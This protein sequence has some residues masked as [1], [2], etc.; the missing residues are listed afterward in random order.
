MEDIIFMIRTL[1]LFILVIVLMMVIVKHV[2][3]TSKCK[4]YLREVLV[5]FPHLLSGP[6]YPVY[7]S[8]PSNYF[9]NYTIDMMFSGVG[10]LEITRAG[11]TVYGK[12]MNGK[13]FLRR[14]S[15]RNSRVK[16]VGR[17]WKHGG[18][19]NWF[20]IEEERRELY[21]SGF[22]GYTIIG[23]KRYTKDLFGMA[24]EVL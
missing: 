19:V 18:N 6:L 3:N 11:V 21:I 7:F 4:R 9:G 22:T 12:L 5:D 17:H 8:L 16:W 20:L 14:Y 23:S 13:G 1:L 24:R 10:Y 15:P 2:R